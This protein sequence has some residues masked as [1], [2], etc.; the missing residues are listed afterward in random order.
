M[1]RD[2]ESRDIPSIRAI[3]EA[4]GL[5]E[6]CFP[7]IDDPLC[8]VKICVE[9]DGRPMMASFLTGTA[10]LFLIL[11][12]SAGTPEERWQA[13]IELTAEMK[14][15]AWEKG[16]NDFSCWIPPEVELSFAKRLRELGFV[17]S[18]WH[19]WTMKL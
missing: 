14:R 2:V 4:N 5:P 3:H 17:R 1:I 7:N 13:L 12:H 10:E 15:R 19:S 6:N 8:L 11:D 9:R 18:P 16:L